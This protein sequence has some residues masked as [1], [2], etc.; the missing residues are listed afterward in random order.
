MLRIEHLRDTTAP[1][2]HPSRR[3]AIGRSRRRGGRRAR[4]SG[5]GRR[6][7]RERYC[8]CAAL[9]RSRLARSFRDADRS[10]LPRDCVAPP[11]FAERRRRARRAR[12]FAASTSALAARDVAPWPPRASRY[13]RRSSCLRGVEFEPARPAAVR[14]HGA[15]ARRSGAGGRPVRSTTSSRRRGGR[16]PPGHG[17]RATGRRSR[18]SARRPT[19]S[20]RG[21]RRPS[22][23]RRRG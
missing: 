22:R 17:S 5:A 18:H 11:R 2:P 6:E 10:R 9:S 23:R 7:V 1:S 19:V 12:A 13:A 3:R 4:R 8:S 16:A 14:R 20:R 21:A 15:V